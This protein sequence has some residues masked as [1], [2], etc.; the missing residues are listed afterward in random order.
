MLYLNK[1]K[2]MDACVVLAEKIDKKNITRK[3]G[4]SNHQGDSIPLIIFFTE[5]TCNLA[6]GCYRSSYAIADLSQWFYS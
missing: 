1:K 6:H 3:Q 4:F 5:A 2:K